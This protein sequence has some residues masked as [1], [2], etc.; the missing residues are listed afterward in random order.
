MIEE[1]D[2]KVDSF[3]YYKRYVLISALTQK[4]KSIVIKL[5]RDDLNWINSKFTD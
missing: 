3:E 2:I 1:L 4:G 5:R